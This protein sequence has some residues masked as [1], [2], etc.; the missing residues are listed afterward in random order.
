MG[1]SSTNKHSHQPR[2]SE[3]KESQL[4]NLAMKLA[5]KKL[6]D[7]TASS[8]VITH[9]L[10]LATAKTQ[11]EAE[12]LKADVKLSSAKVDKINSDR[13]MKNVYE[14]VIDAMK[15]YQGDMEDDEYEDEY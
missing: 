6:R 5:E 4:I 2:T 14:Q 15:K 8:Q 3:G 9:F 11:L 1:K 13:D 12:K 10:R 7:G